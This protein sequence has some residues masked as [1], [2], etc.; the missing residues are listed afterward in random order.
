MSILQTFI[1]FSRKII[2]EILGNL[3]EAGLFVNIFVPPAFIQAFSNNLDWQSLSNGG[4]PGFLSRL[5]VALN[6]TS[7]INRP[8]FGEDGIVGGLIFLADAETLDDFFNSLKFIVSLFDMD[9]PFITSPP[10]PRNIRATS[11]YIKQ[12]DGK[13]KFGVRLEWDAPSLIG[14]EKYKLSRSRISGG[15]TKEQHLMPTKLVGRKGHEEEGIITAIKIRLAKRRPVRA[16]YATNDEYK[17]ALKDYKQWPATLIQVY[18]DIRF[19]KL[20]PLF[21][22]LADALNLLSDS[23]QK[24]LGVQ[25]EPV[26]V[27][28][29]LVDYSGVYIDYDLVPDKEA[30]YYYVI[31]SGSNSFG[32]YSNEVSVTA[33]PKGCI[34]GNASGTVDQ[35]GGNV[36]RIS[37]GFGALGMWS[38]ITAKNLIPFIPIISD[39]INRFLDTLQGGLKTCNKAFVDFL[40]GIV[41]KFESYLAMLEAISDMIIALENFFSNIPKIAMLL[42]PTAKGGIDGFMSRVESAEKPESGF[43]GVSGITM[44]VVFLWGVSIFDPKKI[45]EEW[46]EKIAEISSALVS[47]AMGFLKDILSS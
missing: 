31:Q 38:S 26:Y 18:E 46:D 8:Q 13:T 14:F 24:K 39:F 10:P 9:F 6:N 1:T 33:I 23:E 45:G 27:K 7:D 37:V 29:N 40:L 43:S 44:G 36:E 28:P 3:G 22:P 11:G 35:P 5:K 41:E 2:N 47:E 17:K 12:P 34:P 15:V 32:P 20:T 25:R 4:F 21:L 16:N 19:G 42:V 30:T